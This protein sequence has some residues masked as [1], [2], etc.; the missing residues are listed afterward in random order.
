M[1]N[2]VNTE[3][4]YTVLENIRENYD[5]FYSAEKKVANFIL[6]NA[7]QMLE[8]NVSETAELSGVSDATVVRFCQRIGYT[9]FYQMKLRLSHDLGKNWT[10]QKINNVSQRDSTREQL[11]SISN[12]IITIANYIDT[13]LLKKCAS[14]IDKSD[15]VF[16]IGNGYAKIM[17]YDL[18][19]RLTRMGIRCCG[20][21]YSET[22]FENLYLGKKNDVAIFISRSGE[23][24]KTYKQMLLALKKNMVTIVITDAIKSPMSQLSNFTLTT[25][26]ENRA[27]FFINEKSSCLNMMVLVEVLLEHVMQRHSDKSFLDEVIAEDKL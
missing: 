15:T 8:K 11:I 22:D 2:N 16:V 18:I 21:G 6:D 25:G 3:D 12:N 26:I 23:N 19:Y 9:G 17:A 27:R 5:S 4:E 10:K 13:K 24:K 1:E 14:A 20:G 7:S